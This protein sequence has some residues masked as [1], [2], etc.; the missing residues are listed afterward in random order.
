MEVPTDREDEVIIESTIRIKDGNWQVDIEHYAPFIREVTGI[1]V[2]GGLSGNDCYRIG[3]R[4]QGFIEEMKGDDDWN[5]EAIGS[6]P[7]VGSDGGGFLVVRVFQGM[8]LVRTAP[9]LGRL[10][11]CDCSTSRVPDVVYTFGNPVVTGEASTFLFV[12]FG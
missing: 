6:Y 3:N 4:M 8:S 2:S 11:T 7:V 9:R 1:S 12:E 5:S 10:G